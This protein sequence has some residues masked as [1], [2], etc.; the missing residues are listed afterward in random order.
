MTTEIFAHDESDDA[1]PAKPEVREAPPAFPLVKGRTRGYH[2]AAVD[3]FLAGAR[4]SFERDDDAVTSAHIRE[5]SFP[6]GRNGYEIEAV[7]RAL[8]RLEDAF[9]GRE[10]DRA[11]A[12]RG[13]EEWVTEA[14][15]LAQEVLD[16]LARPRK[17]RFARTG[18]LTFGYRVAE[19]DHV[20]DLI[21]RYLRDGEPLTPEQ[22]RSAAFRMQRRGY[23]EEQVDALLDA[24]VEVILAVR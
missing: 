17:H 23:R 14:R 22:V 5:A 1:A 6:L 2:R 21:T 19:V 9:A 24:T 7:D 18:L 13:R 4:E 16:H 20:A 3:A 15:G 11:I 12:A 8:G 10:R